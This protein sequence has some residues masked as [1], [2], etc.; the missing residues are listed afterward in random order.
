M[1]FCI[2]AMSGNWFWYRGGMTVPGCPD[3]G[4]RWIVFEM[5]G[6]MAVALKRDSY[7][8]WPFSW[9]YTYFEH[10]YTRIK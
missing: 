6:E 2:Q 8:F 10:H 9:N 5:L 4:V 1:T 7:S 3:W